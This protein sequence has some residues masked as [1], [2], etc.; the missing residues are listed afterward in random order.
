MFIADPGSAFF[1]LP[2]PGVKKAPDPGSGSAKLPPTK[3]HALNEVQFVLMQPVSNLVRKPV[4]GNLSNL[5]L[6]EPV[7]LPLILLVH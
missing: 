3:D 5:F 6:Q 1:P 7:A 4:P 2:D